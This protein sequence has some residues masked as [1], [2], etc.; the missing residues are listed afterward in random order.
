MSTND[1]TIW[2]IIGVVILIMMNAQGE[3]EGKKEAIVVVDCNN[4]GAEVVFRT[5]IVNG[6]YI[7]FDGSSCTAVS[8]WIEMELDGLKWN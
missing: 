3:K 2:I 5:N 7:N 8:G 1:K 6:Q 4:P